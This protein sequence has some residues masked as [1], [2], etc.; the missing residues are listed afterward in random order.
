MDDEKEEEQLGNAVDERDRGQRVAEQKE[1]PAC[2][3]R[4]YGSEVGTTGRRRRG[5][6][7]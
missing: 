2:K 6:A 3:E 5:G 4:E 1:E 7:C